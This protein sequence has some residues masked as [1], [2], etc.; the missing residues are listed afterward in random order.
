MADGAWTF[1]AAIKRA[2]DDLNFHA[3]SYLLSGAGN[4]TVEAGVSLNSGDALLVD[5][6]PLSAAGPTITGTTE[7]YFVVTSKGAGTVAPVYSRYVK[8][9]TTWT[10]QTAAD[11][12]PDQIAATMLEIA[13]YQ[14]TGDFFD[15]WIAVAAWWEGAMSQTDKEA[16]VS[17]WRTSDLWNSA[18]GQPKFL[19]ELNVAGAGASDLVGNASSLSATGTTL[20][21]AE[22]LSSWNFNGTGAGGP[23]ADDYFA[24]FLPPKFA[25]IG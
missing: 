4:G 3:L 2:T 10:H 12:V 24:A 18:H 15:G 20:D 14:A 13:A 23:A 22:T 25:G 7:S 8:S 16:L 5:V 19:V 6:P 11:T 9:T 21:A 17:N 1:A